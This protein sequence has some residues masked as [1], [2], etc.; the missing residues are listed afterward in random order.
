M[1]TRENPGFWLA[2]LRITV[3]V[4]WLIA[5]IIKVLNPDYASADLQPRLSQWA[6][7]GHDAI[8]AF[9]SSTLIPNLN[10]LSFALRGLEV[11]IGVSLIFGI[12]TR[13]GAF[14]GFA[15]V[16]GAWILQHGFDSPA[17]YAGSTFIVLVTM[18]FLVFAPAS[19]IFAADLLLARRVVIIPPPPTTTTPPPTAGS[20]VV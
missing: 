18:L 8:G 12:F 11:L 19:R 16:A 9:I 14:C 6:A 15:I 2:F 3:G 13:L 20:A 7:S 4:A 10:T 17:G 5:A 1:L